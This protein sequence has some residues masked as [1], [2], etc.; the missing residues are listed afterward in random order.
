VV[1]RPSPAET[2]TVDNLPAGTGIIRLR[3]RPRGMWT[4]PRATLRALVQMDDGSR[5][6][7]RRL[8]AGRAKNR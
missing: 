5:R 1:H 8:G 3:L 2:V 7:T 4:T 6:M